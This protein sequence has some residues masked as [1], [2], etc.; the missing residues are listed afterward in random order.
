MKKFL[1]LLLVGILV[2]SGF[3]ALAVSD[4]KNYDT[5]IKEEIIIISEPIIK[6]TGQYATVN[7]KE[8]TSFLL[9]P[10]K[11]LLPVVTQVFTLPFETKIISVDMTI[12]DS[13][14][15]ILQKEVQPAPRPVPVDIGI[16]ASNKAIMDTTVYGSSELY[17]TSDYNYITASGL[18]QEE[19]VLY[20][21]VKW[22]PIRYSPL[23]N[24][25]YY[26]TKADIKI[27]YKEPTSQ[28]TFDDIYDLAIIAPSEYSNEL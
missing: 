2:A 16:N 22:Y 14:E 17:P 19:H 9:E 5:K 27:T 1:I 25:I 15:L 20:L 7:I 26:S 10:G 13:K 23:Q 21:V 8:A 12:S 11:P 24:K 3:G 18:K 4:K 28:R 6:E